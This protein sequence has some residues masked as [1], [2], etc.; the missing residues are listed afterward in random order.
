[1]A[2]K[3]G[4]TAKFEALVREYGMI[5]VVTFFSLTVIEIAVIMA[6]LSAGVDIQP[7]VVWIQDWFGWD[8]S[9]LMET[10]GY[11]GIAYAITRV[12]KPLQF[13]AT[14]VLTPLVARVVRGQS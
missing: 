10:A 2:E 3:S 9:G 14:F 6:M 13:A 7:L 5:A 1:M 11:F 12:L 4:V 8:A